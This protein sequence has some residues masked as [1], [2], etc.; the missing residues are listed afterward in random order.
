MLIWSGSLLEN[1]VQITTSVGIVTVP[2]SSMPNITISEQHHSG[3]C[4][5]FQS[6]LVITGNLTALYNKTLSC[7]T[8]NIAS[9]TVVIPP[10]KFELTSLHA[11]ICGIKYSCIRPIL[12]VIKNLNAWSCLFCY[13][14]IMYAVLH[15]RRLVYIR[16]CTCMCEWKSSS[17]VRI[18]LHIIIELQASW[19]IIWL[20]KAGRPARSFKKTLS[21]YGDQ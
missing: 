19:K 1:E 5:C 7:R 21:W 2:S 3:N 8:N 12:K 13:K 18:L 15:W 17:L 14:T 11:C 4:S 10:R 20:N 16:T 6:I 9:I